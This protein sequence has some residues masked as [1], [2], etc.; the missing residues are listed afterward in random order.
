MTKADEAP[1]QLLT[2][3]LAGRLGYTRDWVYRHA[4]SL[5]FTVPIPGGRPRFSAG[6]RRHHRRGTDPPC[7]VA[8]RA[9]AARRRAGGDRPRRRRDATGLPIGHTLGISLVSVNSWLSTSSCHFSLVIQL[10]D[11]HSLHL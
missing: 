5:P 1:D 8:R 3:A 6:V 2:A 4:D 9:A 11:K 10:V 7:G